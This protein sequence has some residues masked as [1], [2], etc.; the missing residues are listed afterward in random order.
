MILPHIKSLAPQLTVPYLEN[1]IQEK[2]E[3]GADFHDELIICYLDIILSIK[4]EDSQQNKGNLKIDVWIISWEDLLLE[5]RK[6]LISFLEQSPFYRAEK[7]L[8]RFPS[9]GNIL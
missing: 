2:K 9:D 6:K 3:Q 1:L 7:M 4:K 8:S 5:T